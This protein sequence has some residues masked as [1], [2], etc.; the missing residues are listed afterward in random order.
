M[1]AR[2]IPSII[3]IGVA[4]AAY[5]LLGVDE[6]FEELI[7]TK[8][9]QESYDYI[10]GVSKIIFLSVHSVLVGTIGTLFQLESSAFSCS[11]H[12]YYNMYVLC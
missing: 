11:R 4:L 9:L 5:R 1:V 6:M 10:V 8:N 2:Y 3:V 7:K 12:E